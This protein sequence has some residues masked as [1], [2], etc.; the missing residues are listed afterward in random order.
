MTQE[1]RLRI[2]ISDAIQDSLG[3]MMLSEEILEDMVDNIVFS[4]QN[5]VRED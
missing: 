1:Q 2:A 3:M 5:L 4:I